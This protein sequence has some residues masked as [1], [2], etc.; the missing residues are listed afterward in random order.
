MSM[1]TAVLPPDSAVASFTLD[2]QDGRDQIAVIMDRSGWESVE[3]PLPHY[4]Y[5]TAHRSPGLAIDVGA[6]TG[7]Y[8][9]LAASASSANRVLAF[10]P[11]PSILD[12]LHRNVQANGLGDRVRLI[13]CAISDRNGHADLH[14][15][16]DEHGLIE[17]SASLSTDFKDAHAGRLD[18]LLRTVDRVMFRPSL[19][20]QPVRLIKIDVEGHDAAVIAG[21]RWTIRRHRPVIFIEV[22][23]GANM[24]ALT[25]FIRANRYEDVRLAPD[26]PPVVHDHVAFDP[27]GWNHA[28]V[29]AE[30][31]R[32]FLD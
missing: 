24:G 14:L 4:L 2:T 27:D 32:E 16:S 9:L 13:R 7:F 3:R 28:L 15:P 22:L 31:V 18:V 10:E 25:R 8:T 5:R 17:T 19:V 6:N 26:R 30:Q 11:V 12:I 21:A 1:A 29:P 20:T 23:Q